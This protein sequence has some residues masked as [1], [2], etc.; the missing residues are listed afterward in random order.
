MG[1]NKSEY[2]HSR[3]VHHQDFCPFKFLPTTSSFGFILPLRGS[4]IEWRSLS[5]VHQTFVTDLINRVSYWQDPCGSV[6]GW[7]TS[8]ISKKTL[9]DIIAEGSPR[10]TLRIEVSKTKPGTKRTANTQRFKR[11]LIVFRV[12]DPLFKP[13]TDR[14]INDDTWHF[15]LIRLRLLLQCRE[16]AEEYT[17]FQQC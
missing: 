13:A 5:R 14:Q 16:C 1:W 3:S 11:T 2:T 17:P 12:T 4:N 8:S 15:L 6:T 9:A 10:F 7:E